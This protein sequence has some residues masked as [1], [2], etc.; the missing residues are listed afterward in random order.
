MECGFCTVRRALFNHLHLNACVSCR[1]CC[2]LIVAGSFGPHV[3]GLHCIQ[4]VYVPH[5]YGRHAAKALVY[6]RVVWQ[7][8]SGVDASLL[9][10]VL[11]SLLGRDSVNVLQVFCIVLHWCGVCCP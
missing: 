11:T 1:P 4:L 9:A 7:H 10:P 5:A 3:L 8:T 6:A 2:L